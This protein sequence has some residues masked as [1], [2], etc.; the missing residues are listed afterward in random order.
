MSHGVWLARSLSVP[1]REPIR[2]GSRPPGSVTQD[3][4]LHLGSCRPGLLSVPRHIEGRR[5]ISQVL[6]LVN[7]RVPVMDVCELMG[8]AEIAELLG[9]SRQRVD[10]LSRRKGSFPQPAAVL[11]TGRVWRRADIEKWARE[12][13]RLP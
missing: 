9:V 11:Q 4:R 12:E 10:A 5:R 3:V 8:V 13:G 6:S 7:R 1:W 2:F